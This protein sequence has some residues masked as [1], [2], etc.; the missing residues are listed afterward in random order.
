V[1]FRANYAVVY[2]GA[3]LGPADRSLGLDWAEQVGDETAAYEFE[4]PTDDTHEPFVG[5]QAFDVGSY[6]HEIEINGETLSGFDIP[7][8]DGWQYW[9]DSLTG[10]SLHEGTN[11]IRIRR[12]PDADDAFAIGTVRIHWK[13]AVES[14]EDESVAETTSETDVSDVSEPDVSESGATESDTT[15]VDPEDT[16]EVVETNTAMFDDSGEE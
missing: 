10:T 15:E 7:P 6:D 11:T 3:Q 5:L 4:V 9:V 16:G 1:R 12:D 2:V 8:N 14:E 13:E